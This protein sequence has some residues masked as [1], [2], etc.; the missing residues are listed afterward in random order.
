MEIIYCD[1]M[2]IPV[3]ISNNIE[4]H[5]SLMCEICHDFKRIENH[6][7]MEIKVEV[8]SEIY[9]MRLLNQNLL[10]FLLD[11]NIECNLEEFRLLLKNRIW[12]E[13]DI[14]KI[15]KEKFKE[16]GLNEELSLSLSSLSSINKRDNDIRYPDV[17]P[18]LHNFLLNC[19]DPIVLIFPYLDMDGFNN[20]ESFIKLHLNEDKLQYLQNIGLTLKESEYL[21]KYMN[22]I[23]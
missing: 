5:S 2:W 22:S 23:F 9:E 18:F 12:N 17:N 20:R 7:E 3:T 15:S 13:T 21:I 11:N 6:I 8:I 10:I 16:M 4:T 14:Y 19:K 1:H